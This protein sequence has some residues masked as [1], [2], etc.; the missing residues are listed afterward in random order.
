MICLATNYTNDTN[1]VLFL[2]GYSAISALKTHSQ[3]VNAE[4]TELT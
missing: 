2:S 4:D 3:K 1:A